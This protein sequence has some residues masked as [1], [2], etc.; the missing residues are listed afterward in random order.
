MAETEAS[1]LMCQRMH[2]VKVDK[3][4]S[5]SWCEG[6]GCHVLDSYLHNCRGRIECQQCHMGN[7]VPVTTI[8]PDWKPLGS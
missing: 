1:C 2:G 6:C 4:T 8:D 7:G 3:G 5:S